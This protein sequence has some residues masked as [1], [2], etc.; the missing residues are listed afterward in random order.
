MKKW[1]RNLILLASVIVLIYANFYLVTD[2]ITTPEDRYIADTATEEVH[3]GYPFRSHTKFW[4]GGFSPA[5]NTWDTRG[6]ALN[7]FADIVIL[8]GI[9]YFL[10]KYFI[11]NDGQS[12]STT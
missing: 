10:T 3:T 11:K 9:W 1:H 5:L 8:I 7:T 4:A 2:R 12:K 6:I